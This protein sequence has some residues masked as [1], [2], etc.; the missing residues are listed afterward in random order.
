MEKSGQGTIPNRLD[1][2]S[3]WEQCEKYVQLAT[4]GWFLDNFTYLTIKLQLE[5]V[6]EKSLV[7]LENTPEKLLQNWKKA[8]EGHKISVKSLG[9]DTHLTEKSK[10]ILILDEVRSITMIS[11]WMGC[12]PLLHSTKPSSYK[13]SGLNNYERFCVSGKISSELWLVCWSVSLNKKGI[14]VLKAERSGDMLKL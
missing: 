5:N 4:T 10:V 14:K 11:L 2:W 13:F 6:L 9:S 1:A 8:Q 12:G 7:L 3:L